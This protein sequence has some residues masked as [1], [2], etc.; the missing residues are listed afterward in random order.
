MVGWE[1]GRCRGEYEEQCCT[2][3]AIRPGQGTW[4]GFW[5][6]GRCGQIEIGC[7]EGSCCP[8]Q[9]T[10]NDESQRGSKI[11]KASDMQSQ[12]DT[13]PAHKDRE[14]GQQGRL[15]EEGWGV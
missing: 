15:G 5:R 9:L 7:R 11:I 3:K 6:R 13:G 14:V 1:S 10:V 12:Q 2:C 8:W 4:V